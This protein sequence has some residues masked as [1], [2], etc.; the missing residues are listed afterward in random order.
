MAQSQRRILITHAAP[1][2]EESPY[3]AI[4]SE[5]K[6]TIDF[7]PFV[8]I[9]GLTSGEFRKQ[10]INPLDFTAI[11]FTGTHPI[12]HFFRLCK[13]LRVEMPPDMKY[14]C[15]SDFAAK[16]LQ[17]YITIRK[18]K[19]YTGHKA[20]AELI[21]LLKKKPKETYLYP[22]G[23]SPRRDLLRFLD[24]QNYN[25]KVAQVYE[26]VARDL[27]DVPVD[28]YDI[29]AFFSPNS[30]DALFENYPDFQQGDT[31]IAVFGKMTTRRAE[32]AGMRLDIM[33][34]TPE[35][36]SMAMALDEHLKNES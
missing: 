15:A 22:S 28:A 36:P 17:K 14:F 1:N 24:E 19:L 27:N 33:V 12:D 34:P 5:H 35:I 4:A 23:D 13:D 32:E 2:S 18:R 11:I 20:M 31:K 7:Q 3:E 26:T 21:E 10:N 30:I 16:Y 9:Q 25:H 8:E 29:L 6:V